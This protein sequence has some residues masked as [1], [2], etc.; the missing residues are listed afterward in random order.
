MSF[1]TS[2]AVNE[3]YDSARA[4][5]IDNEGSSLSR[6]TTSHDPQLLH[7]N[8]CNIPKGVSKRV[9]AV[10]LP[11]SC[12]TSSSKLPFVEDVTMAPSDGLSCVAGPCEGTQE[13]TQKN[14]SLTKCSATPYRTKQRKRMRTR[15]S[16]PQNTH[17]QARTKVQKTRSITEPARP[18]V[19]AQARLLEG[20]QRVPYRTEVQPDGGVA[21]VRH[22]TYT[23]HT[24]K[25]TK[26]RPRYPSPS[27]TNPTVESSQS[28]NPEIAQIHSIDGE[29][30]PEL[31]HS[32]EYCNLC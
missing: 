9:S 19:P 26:S 31:L 20:R 24:R 25:R 8:R 4:L 30:I 14:S 16:N 3:K 21:R 23:V 13:E 10:S 18:V 22:Y 5:I 17:E 15:M 7:S 6:D 12:H 29:S 28:V 27:C 11:P 2:P 1:S 32:T